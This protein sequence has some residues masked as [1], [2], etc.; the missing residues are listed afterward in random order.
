MTWQELGQQQLLMYTTAWCPDCHRLKR[1]LNDRK[2]PVA[3]IDIETHP[4]AAERLQRQTKRTAI[5]FVQ[6]NGGPMVRGWHEEA[7]G[8]FSADI[9][10][11]EA[12]AALQAV[13]NA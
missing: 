8:R 13:G 1:I 7:P 2:V 6:L 10:L 12:A 11:A 5:P 9:F 3:E 4:D